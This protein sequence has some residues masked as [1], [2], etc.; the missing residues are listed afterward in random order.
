MEA[1]IDFRGNSLAFRA[2]D[3]PTTIK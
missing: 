1:P 3:H 2:G